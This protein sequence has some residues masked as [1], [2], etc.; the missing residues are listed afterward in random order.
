M[1]SMLN[2]HTSITWM[3]VSMYWICPTGENIVT[4]KIYP[5][6]LL[7]YFFSLGEGI[8]TVYSFLDKLMG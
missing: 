5:E 8:L 1:L 6:N 3:T 4:F 2:I 7:L